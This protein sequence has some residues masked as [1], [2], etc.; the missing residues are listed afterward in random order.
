M[1]CMSGKEKNKFNKMLTLGKLKK[2]NHNISVC[3]G[4]ILLINSKNFIK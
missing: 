4:I 2:N 1:A 3:I